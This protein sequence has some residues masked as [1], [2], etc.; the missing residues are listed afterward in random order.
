MH[1]ELIINHDSDKEGIPGNENI[2]S[3]SEDPSDFI[4]S[5]FKIID[6]IIIFSLSS[7]GTIV[8]IACYINFYS[9]KR[10]L[11]PKKWNKNTIKQH[12]EETELKSLKEKIY[13]EIKK[14]DDNNESSICNI[15]NEQI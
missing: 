4:I 3:D 7:I 12:I 6:Y 5:Y 2:F 10:K 15:L 14:Q 9:I 1:E 11:S 13:E 8:T